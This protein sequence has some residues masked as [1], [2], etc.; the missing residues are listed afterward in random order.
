MI[1]HKFR[2]LQVNPN[3]RVLF[4][5]TF[6]PDILDEQN[7]ATYYY[8]RQRNQFWELLPTTLGSPSLQNATDQEKMDYMNANDFGLADLIYSLDG[9]PEGQEGSFKD[10]FIDQYVHEWFDTPALIRSLPKLE[11]I[12][13]TRISFT[14][15]VPNMQ[16]RVQKVYDQLPTTVSMCGLITPGRA[17]RNMVV[18]GAQWNRALNDNE[19]RLDL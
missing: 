1:L 11:K 2:D 3:T 15:N 5:G 16:Q 10:T 12:F 14:Q 8:G 4:L 6:N 7:P 13:V 9:I 18:K 17:Y 19:Y